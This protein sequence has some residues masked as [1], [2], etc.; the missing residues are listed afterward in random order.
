MLFKVHYAKD[1]HEL[2]PEASAIEE[3]A[4]LTSRQMMAVAL[5]ADY[6][7][8]FRTLPEKQRR[9]EAAKAAGYPL[10]KEGKRLDSNGRSVVDRR[11]PNVE[12]AIAKYREIQYNEQQAMLEALDAQIQEAMDIMKMDKNEVLK[13][14]YTKGE[15]VTE[16]YYTPIELAKTAMML[17]KGLPELRKAKM[18]ILALEQKDAE[19]VLDTPTSDN[20]TEA[21][22]DSDIPL[23]TIDLVMADKIK[24]SDNNNGHGIE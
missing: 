12:V 18:D 10:E 7:S 2:N 23:S 14:R 22:N 3:F 6:Q 4:R 1:F 19:V 8:P 20:V 9:Y 21:L 13:K 15:T 16:E 17:G 11:T 5:I 24:K